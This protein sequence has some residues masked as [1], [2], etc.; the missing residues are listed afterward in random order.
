MNKEKIFRQLKQIILPYSD[1]MTITKDES[2]E[3][4]LDTKYILKGNKPLF[5]SSVKIKKLCKFLF[6]NDLYFSGFAQ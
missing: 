5:F 6:D 2:D 3:F 1:E 4:Y